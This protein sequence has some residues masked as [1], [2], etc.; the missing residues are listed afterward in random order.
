MNFDELRKK[1]I[2]Q[3]EKEKTSV[4]DDNPVVE[5][6][7]TMPSPQEDDGDLAETHQSASAS[8]SKRLKRGN[9]YTVQELEHL[10]EIMKS[11]L[12]IGPDEWDRVADMHF[13][14]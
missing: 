6:A 10:F 5:T 1:M 7:L 11:I 2:T 8:S 14:T 9:R 4:D 3:I 13:S 12:P